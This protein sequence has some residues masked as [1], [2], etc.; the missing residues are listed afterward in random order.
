MRRLAWLALCATVIAEKSLTP[1]ALKCSG[2]KV[3]DENPETS[4]AF[5]K[6]S[7]LVS[8][9]SGNDDCEKV[10]SQP[11]LQVDFLSFG[12][13]NNG[14]FVTGMAFSDEV[15]SDFDNGTTDAFPGSS[16][17]VTPAP[18]T[19]GYASLQVPMKGY[20]VT[21]TGCE[22]ESVGGKVYLP[23]QNFVSI[24]YMSTND[25]SNEDQAIPP[26]MDPKTRK[27]R[28]PKNTVFCS[29]LETIGFDSN[30]RLTVRVSDVI[31]CPNGTKE[32]SIPSNDVKETFYSYAHT[33]T[34]L[35]VSGFDFAKALNADVVNSISGEGNYG[36][37]KLQP[38]QTG[39]ESLY[40]DT[41]DANVVFTGCDRGEKIG[42]RV[43]AIKSQSVSHG[44]ELTDSK[45]P[46]QNA[47]APSLAHPVHLPIITILTLTSCASF[48]VLFI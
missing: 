44:M 3:L 19:T 21:F 9:P 47:P 28:V 26:K 38:G 24:A 45:N 36:K 33:N 42:G 4:L 15:G 8:C 25:T 40:V 37:Y 7:N 41:V 13:T 17:G 6:A 22:G 27:A 1:S 39:Y 46:D 5:V 43:Y 10:W 32:C 31:T 16:L 2:L 35:P 30:S 11:E 14:R 23:A 12:I 29:G 18:G 20:N 34:G 48:I